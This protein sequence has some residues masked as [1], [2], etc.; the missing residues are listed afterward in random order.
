MET[1]DYIS[2]KEN[3]YER[4]QTRKMVKGKNEN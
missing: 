1:V 4:R 2:E 3:Y